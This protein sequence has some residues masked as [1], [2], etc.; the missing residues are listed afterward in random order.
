MTEDAA[1][2]GQQAAQVLAN[3]VFTEAYDAVVDST[4]Q[5]IADAAIA[6]SETRNQL[7]LLLAAAQAF[8]NELFDFINTA[9]LEAKQAEVEAKDQST[10]GKP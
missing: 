6:D 4:I 2:K 3:P 1:I 9:E 8:K 10:R 7:G 5:S